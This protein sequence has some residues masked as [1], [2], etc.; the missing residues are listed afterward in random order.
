VDGRTYTIKNVGT[1]GNTV[2]LS[3]DGTDL[4]FGENSDYIILDRGDDEQI[5]YET[6]EG[7]G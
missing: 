3:P 7:W 2:T 5:T 4:L 6:T 1:S